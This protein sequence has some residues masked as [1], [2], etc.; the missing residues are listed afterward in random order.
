LFVGSRPQK[1]KKHPTTN[2]P[3][4]IQ[5]RTP[6]S[7]SIRLLSGASGKDLSLDSGSEVGQGQRSDVTRAGAAEAGGSGWKGQM[8]ATPGAGQ[9]GN[10]IV[11]GTDSYNEILGG[12]SADGGVPSVTVSLTN[13]DV[14]QVSG[15]SQ[16]TMTAQ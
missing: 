6:S 11:S 16:G 9:S 3:Q 4:K 15:M 14:I 13:G 5:P 1:A 7:V 12:S 10:S 2:A 8:S